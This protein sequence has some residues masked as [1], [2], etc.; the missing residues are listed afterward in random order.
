M[1]G[2]GT[3]DY[4]EF[5]RTVVGEMN[6]LRK[7]I[8]KK[9]FNKFDKNGNGVIEVDDLIDIYNA[10]MHPDVRSGKKT[11]EE[12]F[13]DFIDNFE[14]HFA[15]RVIINNIRIKVNQKIEELNSKNL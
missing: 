3:I 11:E 1:D 4:E 10:R 13:G 8:V 2:S 12:V 6:D 7:N 9:A 15:I 14:N 5:V